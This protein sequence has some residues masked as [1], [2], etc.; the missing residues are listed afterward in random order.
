[1]TLEKTQHNR[2]IL[3]PTTLVAIAFSPLFVAASSYAQAVINKQMTMAQPDALPF[4][5][6]RNHPQQKSALSTSTFQKSNSS[7]S[8]N[9]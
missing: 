8:A 3:L 4:R 5:L 2:R 1:M 9:V 7:I 6:R